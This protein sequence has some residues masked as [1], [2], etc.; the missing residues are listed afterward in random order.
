MQEG[1]KIHAYVLM[2][3]HVHLLL[4]PEE[5]DSAS[6]MMK[7]LGERYVPEFNK[8]HGRTGTLWE[9]RFRSSVIDTERYFIECQRYIELNPVRADIVLHPREYP[10]SSY[11]THAEG[12]ASPFLTGHACYLSLASTDRERQ[13]AYQKLFGESMSK[14][15]LR[16]IRVSINSGAPL[17]DTEFIAAL[18]REAG[19]SVARGMRVR[20]PH[21]DEAEIQA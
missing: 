5:R 2:S 18:E 20:R 19:R 17:G 14:E 16:R 15:E 13:A 8:R 11:R 12:R 10:W 4:S 9:G 6:R 1:C 7:S 3:N 21:R